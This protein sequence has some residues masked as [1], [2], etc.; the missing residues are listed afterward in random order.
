MRTN[1]SLFSTEYVVFLLKEINILLS[2]DHEDDSYCYQ[3]DEDAVAYDED[4][5]CTDNG[6]DEIESLNCLDILLRYCLKI[7]SLLYLIYL[8]CQ[9][10]SKVPSTK[11]SYPCWWVCLM[12]RLTKA[13]RNTPTRR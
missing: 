8:A 10:V 6:A 13:V 7:H 9:Q 4:D 12:T 11:I 2:T 3:S 5:V 1:K